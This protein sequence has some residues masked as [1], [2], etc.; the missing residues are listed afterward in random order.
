M[1]AFAL[2]MS[3]LAVAS[4]TLAS[5]P[6]TPLD[7]GAE[8]VADPAV[9]YVLAGEVHGTK[10]LPAA[11]ADL[12]CAA[13]Q[14][15]KRPVLVG[16][17]HG[18]ISQAAFDAYL[19]SNGDD[20]ARS[21]LLAAPTWGVPGGRGSQAMLDVV[22]AVRRMRVHGGDVAIVAFDHEIATPGTTEA[23]EQAM[24]EQLV[25][26]RRAR[27]GALVVAL[28]GL[29]HADK[30]GFT[31]ATPAMRSMAGFLPTERALSLDFVR[32]GGEG[33]G[34]R[35]PEGQAELTCGPGPLPRREAEEPRGVDRTARR[36]G[37]DGEMSTGTVLT[38]SPPARP[39]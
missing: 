6:C 17:E 30:Q 22:E 5:E 31:S 38:A 16:L 35:R 18:P 20:E 7:G 32:T 21:A 26:A 3:S 13:V 33:W 1:G 37:F 23:R 11:F 15:A 12:V 24:A 25:A 34:C 19:A 2:I 28:T 29:G 39:G 9:D 14:T 10:E 4:P 27:P 36:S 8:I